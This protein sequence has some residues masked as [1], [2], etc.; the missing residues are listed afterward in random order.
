MLKKT[1]TTDNVDMFSNN[2]DESFALWSKD[3]SLEPQKYKKHTKILSNT[4]GW[5]NDYRALICKTSY[6]HVGSPCISGTTENGIV[7]EKSLD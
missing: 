4:L 5:R 6:S 7:T 1:H 2:P 3:L